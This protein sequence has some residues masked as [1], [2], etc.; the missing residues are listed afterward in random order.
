MLQYIGHMTEGILNI[1]YATELVNDLH[2]LKTIV[3]SIGNELKRI[4][5]KMHVMQHY[6]R[7]RRRGAVIVGS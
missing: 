7:R 2:N 5:Q 1:F 6:P 4:Y 3:G